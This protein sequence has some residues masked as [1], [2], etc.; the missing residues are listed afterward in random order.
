VWVKQISNC[1]H[2]VFRPKRTWT[3]GSHFTEQTLSHKQMWVKQTITV[4]HPKRAQTGKQ[5]I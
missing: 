4:V 3:G 1:C 2:N 5:W